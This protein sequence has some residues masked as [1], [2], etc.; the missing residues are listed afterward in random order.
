VGAFGERFKR[1]RE[2]RKITLDEVAKAT[3]IGTRLLQAIEE[4]KFDQ[5]PGGMFNKAFVRSYARHLG[6]NEDQAAAEYTEIYRASHPEDPL[7]D[8]DAEGRKILEQRAARVQQDRRHIVHLPWGKAAVALLLVAFGF[9]V[10]GSYSRFIKS[11]NRSEARKQKPAKIAEPSQPAPAPQVVEASTPMESQPQPTQ[12]AVEN[13]QPAPGSF[14]V[15]IKA[16]EDSWIH[17]KVDGTDLPEETLAAN[18]EKSVQANS[19][20]VVKAGNVGAVDFWFNGQKVPA[21]GELDQVKTIAFGPSGLATH[22]P[23]VQPV[24]DSVQQ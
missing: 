20:V 3:K 18:T 22:G 15:L 7:A 12:D 24:S 4:E 23:K 5:L 21:Q 6:I 16:R 2:K 10:W 11:S 17:I 9:A 14:A 1:E 8:P 13:S 19:E